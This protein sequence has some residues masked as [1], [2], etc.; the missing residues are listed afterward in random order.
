MRPF[1][2]YLPKPHHGGR[3]WRRG[4]QLRVHMVSRKKLP[5]PSDHLLALISPPPLSVQWNNTVGNTGL[6]YSGPAFSHEFS[7]SKND[8]TLISTRKPGEGTLILF[9]IFS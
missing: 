6:E 3:I 2:I 9:K 8:I 7:K 1:S 5:S 4:V